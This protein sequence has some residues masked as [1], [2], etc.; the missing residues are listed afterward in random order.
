M[1]ADGEALIHLHARPFYVAEGLPLKV[2]S[3]FDE[4]STFVRKLPVG[5]RLHVVE[6]TASALWSS[7]MMSHQDG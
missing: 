1:T 5:T 2:R 3:A 6:S 4:L 7:A